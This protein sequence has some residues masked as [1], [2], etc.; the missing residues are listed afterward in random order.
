MIIARVKF[1]IQYRSKIIIK[2]MPKY[3]YKHKKV[4]DMFFKMHNLVSANEIKSF[5]VTH[6]AKNAHVAYT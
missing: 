3:V 2:P 1:E 4:L 5:L 6:I